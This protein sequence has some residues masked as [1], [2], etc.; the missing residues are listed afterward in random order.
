MRR[1]LRSIGAGAAALVAAALCAVAGTTGVLEGTVRDAKTGETLPGVNIL[2]VQ[3]RIGTTTDAKG[4]FLL[5]N[6]RPG[7]YEIRFT[8]VGYRTKSLRDVNI[9]PDVRTRLRVT[10]D[11]TEVQI[12]EVVVVQ[13]R[14]VIQTDVTSTAFMVRSEDLRILPI[15]EPVEVL[16]F[17]PGVTL[18]GNIRGG[19]RTEVSYLVDGL[20][21]QDMVRGGLTSTLP[22]SSVVGMSVYTGGFEAEYGNALSGVVNMVTRQGSDEHRLYFRGGSDNLFGVTQTSKWYEGEFSLAGPLLAEKVFYLAALSGHTQDG[23]WWQDFPDSVARPLESNLNAFAKLDLNVSPKFRLGAQFLYSGTEWDNYEFS[24]RYNLAGLPPESRASNRI[25]L[26][27]SHTISDRFFYTASLSRY[28]VRSGIGEGPKETVPMIPYQYDFFLL[29]II[30]GFR[31]LWMDAT[32]E[33]YTLKFDATLTPWQDHLV[34]FGA[35]LNLYDL[36]TDIAKFEPRLTYFGKPLVNEPQLD[37]ST[38]YQYGPRTG[39]AYIQDK[40]DLLKEGVLLTAGLRYDFLDARASRPAIDATVTGDTAV[41][42]YG[43]TKQASFK[44]QLSPRIGFA[45]PV[46]EKGYVFF[47]LGWYFQYPLFDYLYTGLDRVGLTQ[48]VAAVTGNPD[49]EPERSSS[50]EASFK[51]ALPLDIVASVAYFQRE[52]SNLTD[53]KTFVSGDSK[54]AGDFG[55]AEFVNVPYA[56]SSGIEI[57]LAREKGALITGELS[58]TYMKA[59]GQTEDAYDGY[60][61]AQ[62]GLPPARR[63]SP[64]SWDQR[65]TVKGRIALDLPWQFHVMVAGQ[66]HSGRP[67]TAYPTSTG[68]EP[69]D[70]GAF[71]QNN[72]R[73]PE[74]FLLDLKVEKHFALDITPQSRF[75]IYVDVRNLTD[76]KN[77]SWMDSNGRVGGELSDPGGYDIGRRTRVGI[78]FTL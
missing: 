44:Q 45:T 50:W 13:G 35:E 38:T 7:S 39:S 1:L 16:R 31:S 60:Y 56:T 19:K 63:I 34:R 43:P 10:L 46:L 5:Q 54:V 33:S 8:H 28:F 61:I 70:A 52:S 51:Y 53:T 59:E 14:P 22:L 15:T 11:P 36:Q 42:V 26:I 41:L 12:D 65:H 77:V 69:I 64:L 29:Y 58:Y 73:M 9:N 49:L 6:L 76:Q 23:R 71:V 72:A 37:F 32:Q 21:V 66:W 25:A 75:T 2:L 55:F 74:F 3:L 62:Y 68:F 4:A 17:L 27:A 20:P 57:V 47:N 30:D 18:E 48:G 24:W 78:Q 40:V 67:Y